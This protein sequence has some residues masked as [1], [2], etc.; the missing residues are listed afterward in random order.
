[1]KNK[2]KY[3]SEFDTILVFLIVAIV[4]FTLTYIGIITN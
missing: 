1:M 4:T 2:M 3:K